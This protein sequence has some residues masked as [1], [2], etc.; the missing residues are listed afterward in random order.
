MN[1][2]DLGWIPFFEAYFAPHREQGF[3]PARVAIQYRDKYVMYGE[4]GEYQGQVTGKFEYNAK[5]PEDFP[6][7]GDWVAISPPVGGGTAVIQA[8]LERRT[9]FSRKV[10]G[11]KTN[12]QVVAANADVV[13]LVS[14][15]DDEINL[16]RIE[17][18]LTVAYDS[19]ARPVVVLNKLDLCSDIAPILAEVEAIA[20]GVDV[21]A[22]SARTQEGID[23]IAA[24][25]DK[26]IT[27]A[28]LGSSGVGKTSIA[29]DL[30][31]EERYMTQDVRENDSHGRHTTTHR[32]LVILPT[33]G[34][35][36]DT[37]GMRE[38]QMWGDAQSLQASFEDIAALAAGCKFRGCRHDAEPGCNVKSALEDGRL[39]P[40]R[41]DSYKKLEREIAYLARRQDQNL[42]RQENEKWKKLT[43]EHK[44]SFKYRNRDK[45]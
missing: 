23:R 13:F 19:G 18:Y 2:N 11:V 12:E 36:I 17:R 16:R 31:G 10:A 43:A 30:I 37:P 22:V 45:L 41:Y 7:V 32:E 5:G 40:D 21:L 24:C 35:L 1:L 9:K 38:I 39:A 27:G 44:R 42:Q 4:G 8:V 34:L 29:N 25:L 20:P 3:I 33:G 28:L 6:A 15:L 26:G 14:G